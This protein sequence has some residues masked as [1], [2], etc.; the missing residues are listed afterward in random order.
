[1]RLLKKYANR[2]IYDTQDSIYITLADIREFVIKFE[3]FRIIDAKTESDLT[4]PILLQIISEQESKFGKSHKL[5]TRRMLQQLIRTYNNPIQSAT[6]VYM[7]QA[8]DY[9]YSVH[10]RPINN[11]MDAWTDVMNKNIETWQSLFSQ[12]QP[13]ADSG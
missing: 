5:F 8:L 13:P 6:A 4:A 7:E 3:E 9:L 12:K 10:D 2:R 1:M 11:P